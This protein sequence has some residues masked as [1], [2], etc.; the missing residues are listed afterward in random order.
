[1]NQDLM[2][3]VPKK[4]ASMAD[5]PEHRMLPLHETALLLDI[6]GTLLDLAPTPHEVYVPPKLARSLSRLLTRMNGALALVSGRSLGDIDRIF[7][8]MLF[9]ASALW[10]RW[11][12]ASRF[13][14]RRRKV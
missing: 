5:D 10:N 2:D 3:T 14:A 9:P 7:A 6:D 4:T 12:Q 13:A 8:P 11:R 1:M